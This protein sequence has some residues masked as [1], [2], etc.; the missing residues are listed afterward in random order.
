MRV[1]WFKV[2]DSY[3]DHPKTLMVSLE[4]S[5]L[6]VR[7]AAWTAHYGTDGFIPY[8]VMLRYGGTDEIAGEL[9]DAGFWIEAKRSKTQANG[10]KQAGFMM[11]DF[12]QYNPT[13]NE[14]KALSR[15]RS[16]AGR[17]GG[18]RSAATRRDKGQA[19][20]QASASQGN[21]A[22]G[23]QVLE[24]KTNPVPTRP[25]PL[26]SQQRESNDPE[27][28]SPAG[29]DGVVEPEWKQVLQAWEP[30]PEHHR[31]AR[32]L[33][34]K[35]PHGRMVDVLR[36][37]SLFRDDILETGNKRNVVDFDAAFRKKL[38]FKASDLLDEPAPEPE[39][40]D[41]APA[42]SRSYEWGGITREWIREHITD[43]VPEG[44]FT[45]AIESSF[46]GQV[47]AGTSKEEA[48]QGIVDDL[49]TQVEYVGRTS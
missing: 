49:L 18:K 5:G 27:H 35:D 31:L 43:L 45:Q 13:G 48:A 19:N 41:G 11:H 23:R 21:E 14:A 25:D 16:D 9:M 20:G 33:A 15:Q 40:T 2:D 38:R 42:A 46:W 22:N 24:A 1:S 6:W 37:A 17:K 29:F 8:Q 44:L 30:K 26:L 12:T 7:C 47:K 36:V 32:E 4:A 39:L 28:G 34:D 10:V 3:P